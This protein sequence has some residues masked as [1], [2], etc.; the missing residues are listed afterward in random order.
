MGFQTSAGERLAGTGIPEMTFHIEQEAVISQT[1]KMRALWTLEATQDLKAYHNLDLERELTD[2]LGKELRLEIDREGIEDIRML[3]YGLSGALGGANLNLMDND[4]I[5]V[6]G[7]GIV[8]ADNEGEWVPAQFTYDFAGGGTEFGSNQLTANV[9]VMDFASTAMNLQPRH[10]GEVYANLLALI[11]IA[12]Q[13]IYT[14]TL[15]GPG[16]WL[17][18]SP[19]MAALLESAAKLEGGV[20]PADGPTNQK[21][22]AIEYRGKFMG[23]YDLFVDPLYP[24]DE[25]MIGY[26]GDNA[27][28]AGYVHCPY[29]PIQSLPTV[30]DPETFQPRKGIITRYGKALVQPPQ[31][32]Y[33]IIRVVGATAN[34]MQFPIVTG[35]LWIGM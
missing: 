26:K 11:N 28:D 30:T 31:R 2:L 1:R 3:A 33:R 10:L 21:R 27:M 5:S 16:N 22:N 4:Y 7:Q 13:D 17:L 15:R 34:Y 18:T 14:S 32:F 19:L 6:T 25:I 29:I 20:M 35:K 24:Q 9:F 12:S 23:R 8:D